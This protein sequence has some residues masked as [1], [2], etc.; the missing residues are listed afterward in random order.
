[1]VEAM[2]DYRIPLT[3]LSTDGS[4]LTETEDAW[5]PPVVG[6]GWINESGERFRVADV[7]VV[8]EKRGALGGYGVYAVVEPASGEDDWP[9]TAFS[10]Y[11]N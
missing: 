4:R 5:I 7:W 3:Y 9:A 1:M 11:R 6:Q 2:A 8:A 10:W